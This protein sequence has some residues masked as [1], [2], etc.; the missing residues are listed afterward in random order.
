MH[1]DAELR[2]V[3]VLPTVELSHLSSIVEATGP[4]IYRV[5]FY[6]CPYVNSK[7]SQAGRMQHLERKG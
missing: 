2:S 7:Y 1:R 4:S 3:C 5:H 6:S